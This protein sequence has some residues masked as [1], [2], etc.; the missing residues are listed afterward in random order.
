MILTITIT[1]QSGLYAKK[2]YKATIEVD[3]DTLL[4]D[5]HDII[6]NVIRFDNENMFEFYLANSAW[7]V[8]K[9]RFDDENEEIFE[10]TI[11]SFF[12]LPKHKKLFYFYDWTHDWLF[13]VTKERKKPFEPVPAHKYPRI[14]EQKGKRPLQYGHSEY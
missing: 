1:L 6:Q 3:E 12:P 13:R 2:D 9:T 7:G 5:L 11:G 8:N 4:D 14:V 10:R